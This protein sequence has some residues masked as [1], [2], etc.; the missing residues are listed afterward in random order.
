M[1][2]YT[3]YA[4]YKNPCDWKKYLVASSYIR[5]VHMKFRFFEV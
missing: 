1:K 5:L 4:V 2:T 3:G